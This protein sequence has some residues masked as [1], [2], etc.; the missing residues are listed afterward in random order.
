MRVPNLIVC[1]RRLA[2]QK[3]ASSNRRGTNS[4][5][6]STP[7]MSLYLIV[8]KDLLSLK[9]QLSSLLLLP[10]S[11]FYSYFL[12]ASFFSSFFSSLLLFMQSKNINSD[13]KYKSAGSPFLPTSSSMRKWQKSL[14]STSSSQNF[15]KNDFV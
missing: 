15:M 1:M 2:T 14:S 8:A 9:R 5:I 10:F 3:L 6:P 11:I 7:S 13:S 4:W 12:F